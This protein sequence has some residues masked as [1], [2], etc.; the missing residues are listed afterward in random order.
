MME[1]TD[2]GF[3]LAEKDLELRGPGDFIGTRQSGLPEMSWIGI[4]SL[5]ELASQAQHAATDVLV[6]DPDLTLPEHAALAAK[7]A[8]F[9]AKVSPDVPLAR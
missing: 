7:L 5:T 3:A 9:W 6:R 4:E 2:N 1:A 8:E